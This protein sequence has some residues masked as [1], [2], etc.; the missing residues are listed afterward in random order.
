MSVALIILLPFLGAIFPALMI[1]S[2]RNACAIATGTINVLALGLLLTHLPA[3]SRGETVEAGWSWVPQLGLNVR[4][5]IDGLSMLFAVMI[6]AIG[7]LV[8]IYAR[9]YLSR[10]DPMGNFYTYLLLFQGA[11]VGVVLSNNTLLMI[12]FWELT[13]LSSFLLIGFWGHLPAGRQGA[14][15]ALAVT[16]GGGLC[17]IAG[18]L[19][20][21]G[22]VG[23][24][25]FTDILR[26][27]ELI[28]ESEA[29]PYLLV[30][31]LIGCF[32]KSAQFPFH[33]WLPHAM[34]APTPVSAY[35]HSATMVKAGIYLMARLWPVMSGTDT[36]FYIV[37]TTG[38]VTM[39]IG[40]VLALFEDDLKGLLAY[41]TVSHLGLITM[42]LGM[43]G[44]SAAV[45]AVFH[46]MNHAT[47]KAA[48]FMNA[49]IIDHE[50]GT[51]DLKR[52]GGLRHFMPITTVLG[53]IAA[54]SM[55]GLPPL[56]GFLSKE[57]MLEEAAHVKWLGVGWFFATVATLAAM[58]SVAYSLRYIFHGFFGAP[59]SD[60]P[61]T[62]HDPGFGLW[63][64]SA[65]LVALVVLCGLF[66]ETLVGV[67]LRIAATAVLRTPP[68]D[69][70]LALWHGW[71]PALAMSAIAVALGAF[72]LAGY[73]TVRASWELAP[74]VVAKSMFD[75]VVSGVRRACQATSDS[76]HSGSQQFY[77]Y[78]IVLSA[79]L[80][81]AI[82]FVRFEH[83]AGTRP[84]LEMNAMLV[85][86]WLILVG[87]C[88]LVV[89]KH[90]NRLLALITVNVIGLIS[91]L[92][93]VY[94]SAPDLALTQISVE[95]VTLILML[96][97]LYF[98]PKT[99]IDEHDSLHRYR[100]GVLACL[101]GLG[102][103]GLSWAAMTRD[104]DSISQYYIDNSL[105]G[106]GGKNVVNVI[107]VDFRGFDTF[108]EIMVLG[109][110]ALSI[111]A[112]L[113]GMVRG[114]CAA[115]LAAWIPDE[116]KSANRHPLMMVVVTR[117][118]LPLAIMVGIFIFLRGHNLPGGGFIA[119][120]VISIALIMQYMASGF[121]WAAQQVRFDYHALI[122]GG[123]LI[124]A[125]TGIGAMVLDLPFL[126]SGFTYLNWPIIGKFEVASAMLFD[127]GVFL[128]VVGA[129]ML[130][131]AQLSLLGTYTRDFDTNEEPMD[132]DP[133]ER[134][135]KRKRKRNRRASPKREPTPPQS[136]TEID[137]QDDM[138]FEDVLTQEHT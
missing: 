42:L 67:P 4:F 73:T 100:D 99:S 39:L 92:A 79:L 74:A 40:A 51:R 126:T 24:Y 77:L 36:W 123:G 17:L 108:G 35:L 120:L 119:A 26:S 121:Q 33:F 109:I 125:A 43:G 37:A 13:S 106:G 102:V 14:R 80:L 138:G 2:G 68:D 66:P 69:F 103:G 28:R 88:F 22:V 41:S 130:A 10:K 78:L 135:L 57:M 90:R 48:L 136:D 104:F 71:T 49:G 128:T 113:E 84:L 137:E 65:L 19:L 117:L 110:A 59:R 34:A 91:C 98:L 60:Y 61:Q 32:T 93:F 133:S 112:L 107:L 76:I 53:V 127:T 118:M 25:D 29:Y 105:P 3:V 122:G 21:G 101:A 38:L 94:L 27:G 89:L 52:L 83:G 134:E 15:M 132:V 97:A 96:L 1:R 30:L 50:A 47:F 114:K 72:L 20:L 129:V 70:Y 124:A 75:G 85:I 95:V 116:P 81:G 45:A 18:V 9:F 82:N 87:A 54:A 58:A 44:K 46:I 8:V 62:P 23:S 7:L 63:G 16:A 131:L 111:F 86:G 55:A 5:F 64:P 11:M 115:K 6:L 12:V 31:V 56:N